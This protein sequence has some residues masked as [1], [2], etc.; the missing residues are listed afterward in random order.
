MS[1]IKRFAIQLLRLRQEI[2]WLIQYYRCRLS[3]FNYNGLKP[4]STES[5]GKVLII[6][7]HAD[8]EWIG[9]YSILQNAKN[10]TVFYCRYYGNDYSESNI[11]IRDAEI[12]ECSKQNEYELIYAN[13]DNRLNHLKTILGDGYDSIFMPSPFDWHPEH[14]EAFKITYEALLGIGGHRPDVFCYSISIPQRNYRSLFIAKLLKEQQISKWTLFEDIYKSQV[15][16]IY[17]Y[18]LQERL[19]ANNTKNYAGEI[20]AQPNSEELERD[21]VLSCNTNNEKL[22]SYRL[23]I[24]DIYKIREISLKTGI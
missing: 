4:L 3:G 10:A 12:K 1:V 13:A 17:R 9:C 8:D 2:K 5:L 16:P 11:I 15:M 19:N 14:R 22:D 6:A 23:L 18:K 20:Y 21:Y 7:P 24:N